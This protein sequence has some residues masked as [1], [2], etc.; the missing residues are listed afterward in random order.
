MDAA[1]DDD[2]CPSDYEETCPV[3]EDTCP[4][5]DD[6][7]GRNGDSS[8]KRCGAIV[9]RGTPREWR[10]P[11]MIPV[12]DPRVRCQFHLDAK[13]RWSKS[14]K[15]KV[16]FKRRNSLTESKEAIE[17]WRRENRVMFTM[18][19]TLRSMVKGQH[20]GPVTFPRLGLFQTSEEAEE[21]FR[22]MFEPWMTMENHGQHRGGNGYKVR[23]NIGHRLPR[24]IFD[25]HL[26]EDLQK[27]WNP[28]NLFP[29]CARENVENNAKLVLSDA[30]LLNLRQLWPAA[31]LND[32]GR[33]KKL[34]RLPRVSKLD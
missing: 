25:G 15:G 30:Q 13:N 11:R 19:N 2:M 7:W 34:F 4:S 3:V 12:D 1:E 26:E 16:H 5:D 10:C 8:M 24:R 29:Q 17:K 31:A 9:R 14:D 33:L 28:L 22:S 20:P 18:T 6:S 21:H 32:L 23:W 27:C